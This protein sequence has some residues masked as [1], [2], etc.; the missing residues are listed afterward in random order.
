MP[1]ATASP[2]PFSYLL[3]LPVVVAALG[4]MV[5]M[6]DL[7]LFNIVRVPSLKD[8]G[9]TTEELFT[10]GM[11]ILDIQMAGMLLGGILWGI[12]GDKR[13]RR[14]VL[15]GSILMYSLANIANGFVTSFDQYV[16]LRFIAGIGLA[17]ELGAGITLVAE[18]LPK[19]VRGYGTTMVATVGVFGAI[20]AYFISD[21]FSWRTSYFVGGGLGLALLALRV[22]VF[23][24]GMFLKVLNKDVKRGNFFML[25]SSRKRLFK[26]ISSILIGTPIWFVSGVLIFFSPE[27][28]QA[29]GVTEPIVA[30]KAVMLA[31]AGQVL[32]DIISG[33]MSQRLKSRK[34]GMAI[35]L[36]GSYTLML[37]YLLTSTQSLTTFYIICACLGFFNGYWTL[38]VTIAAEL[39]GSN[40]RAT[41]ATTVPNFVRASV[42]PISGLF[43]LLKGIYG[44]TMGAVIVGTIVVAIALL[45]LW[46]LEETFSKDL[47][48][49][50]R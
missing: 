7:F 38:F 18:I 25:F 36:L 8:L 37:V 31:F 39:F 44:L 24:S 46:K 49:E 32:G 19:H 41:V 43:V 12:L 26:Y 30:G 11:F 20:L 48:Y 42:I 2:S 10:K 45:F 28:G 3:K 17:G 40:L 4:Y 16:L 27:F 50:E 23:E 14:S 15:F 22:G 33:A 1:S 34:K 47:D 6:Y 9:L 29:L 21:I 13:G 5:D 35:F